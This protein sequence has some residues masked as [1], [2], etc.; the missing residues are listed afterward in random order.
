MRST[1]EKEKEKRKRR[2]G[3]RLSRYVRD[4]KQALPKMNILKAE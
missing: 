4:M 1:D 3:R 2:E